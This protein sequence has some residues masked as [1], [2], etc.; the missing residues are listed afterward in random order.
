MY[1]CIMDLEQFKQKASGKTKSN[2]K[3]FER[4]KKEKSHVVDGLF[5][6]ADEEV[7]ANFNCLD[8]ANCCK[9]TGPLFTAKDVHKIAAHLKL[10]PGEFEAEYLKRDEDGDLIL[11]S[12]PC[13]FLQDDNRC[14]IY[15]VRPK[16]CAEYP[17]TNK[18]NIKEILDP[19]KKDV[20]VCPAVFE[21]IEKIKKSI[22]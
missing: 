22:D 8:C 4:L 16:A 9:T 20:G 17:R 1:F 6:E 15:E 14:S 3:F 12:V 11:K 7:F 19:L 10:K 2:R 21:M 18:R 13:T 5:Q